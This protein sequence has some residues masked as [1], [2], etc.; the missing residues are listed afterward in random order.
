MNENQTKTQE[1]GVEID[2][3]GILRALLSK[4]WL[5]A[6]VVLI[7][8]IGGRIYSKY[9]I[10][11][12]YDSTVSIYVINNQ[13]NTAITYTDTQ[14]SLQIIRD[15]K[16][17]IT[18]REVLQ[19]TIDNAGLNCTTG[20]LRGKISLSNE[21]DTRIIDITVR[22]AN[23]TEA[24]RIAQSLCSVSS[25]YIKEI[26]QL[27]AVK[28][29]GDPSEPTKPATP[30]IS[31]WTILCGIVA[32]LIIVLILVIIFLL[33]NTIKS[34]KDVEKYLGWPTLA[35]I[36]V[37]EDANKAKKTTKKTTKKGKKG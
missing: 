12:K 36:P 9:F 35:S 6:I 26:I 31:R 11:P 3:V 23:P 2:I 28:Q 21:E 19:R 18:C 14:L 15:Y 16:E 34:D 25:E 29:L 4:I 37:K 13:E 10:T 32:G 22:D 7:G 24:R 30:S 33:D 5:I 27:E 1:N 17:L 8:A 20:A